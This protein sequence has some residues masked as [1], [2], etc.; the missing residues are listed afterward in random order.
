M[1]VPFRFTKGGRV[2][3]RPVVIVSAAEYH[4]DRADAIAIAL[5]TNLSR[6]YFGDC[7][8]DDWK[9][10]GLPM[11]SLAKGVVATIHRSQ[12]ERRLGTLTGDDMMRIERSLRDVMAL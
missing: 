1:L 8:I 4:Q 5:T 3:R 6:S 12:V 2:K 11:P 7:L 10:A 9:F